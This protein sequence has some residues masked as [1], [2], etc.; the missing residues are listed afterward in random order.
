M[1]LFVLSADRKGMNYSQSS[2]V[3]VVSNIF[4]SKLSSYDWREAAQAKLRQICSDVTSE[5]TRELKTP[6]ILANKS[7]VYDGMIS[8]AS[9]TKFYAS[10][11]TL[12]TVWS[13]QW[14]AF[15]FIFCDAALSLFLWLEMR[16]LFG[17]GCRAQPAS[18]PNIATIGSHY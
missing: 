17:S 12:V 7:L 1:L 13:F 11:S 8:A 15:Y 5:L 16:F 2:H 4:M 14:S 18:C 3:A 6:L 9:P 10:L